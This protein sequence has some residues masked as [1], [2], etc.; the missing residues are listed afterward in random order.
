[1][2]KKEQA[3]MPMIHISVADPD[4][5]MVRDDWRI[6][7]N[8]EA[9]NAILKISKQTNRTVKDIASRL[10]IAAASMVVIDGE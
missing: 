10:I 1:M 3:A 6:R 7:C 4:A 5:E 2:E 9:Y 8:G